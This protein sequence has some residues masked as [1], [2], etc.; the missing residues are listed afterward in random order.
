MIV[1]YTVGATF[2][3]QAYATYLYF[4]VGI[5]IGLS[6][7]VAEQSMRAALLAAPPHEVSRVT[8][9]A[10]PE[11]RPQRPGMRSRSVLF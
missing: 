7:V 10:R 9:V 11:R 2:L 8:A 4:A 5:L 6:R 3:S 1:G